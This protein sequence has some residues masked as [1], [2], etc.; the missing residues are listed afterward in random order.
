MRQ[1]VSWEDILLQNARQHRESLKLL[2]QLKLDNIALKQRLAN[3]LKTATTRSFVEWAE[4]LQVQ[5]LQNDQA[6]AL[7]HHD[8]VMHFQQ[9]NRDGRPHQAQQD[10]LNEDLARMQSEFELLKL[11]CIGLPLL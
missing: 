4:L 3:A 2:E 5:L 1:P 11:Q 9:R 8:L 7:L 10:S 6:L